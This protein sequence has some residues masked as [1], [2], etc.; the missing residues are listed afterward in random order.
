LAKRKNTFEKKTGFNR[1]L[2]GRP[3]HGSTRQISRIFVHPGL[4]LYPDRF[5][6]RIDLLNWSGFNNYV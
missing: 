6:H 2:P 3:D 5:S 1:V 4:L